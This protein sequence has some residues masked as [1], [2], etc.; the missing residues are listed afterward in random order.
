MSEKMYT[1]RISFGDGYPLDAVIAA[2]NGLEAQ[3]Q[4]RAKYPSARNIYLLSRLPSYRKSASVPA[5]QYAL[6]S[7]EEED[8]QLTQEDK[9]KTCVLMRESG[10]S[11]QAIA[12]YLGVGKSTIGRWLKQHG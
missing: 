5:A 9:V 2:K 11:H 6:P 4:A 12:G 7:D 3:D 10:H 8:Q 1:L